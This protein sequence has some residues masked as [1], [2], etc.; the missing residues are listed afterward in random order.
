MIFSHQRRRR[1][2]HKPACGWYSPAVENER[3]CVS[4]QGGQMAQAAHKPKQSSPFWIALA[5]NN[6][7][8]ALYAGERFRG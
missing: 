6:L 8:P 2:T 4:A 5:L 1:G 3:F 7:R